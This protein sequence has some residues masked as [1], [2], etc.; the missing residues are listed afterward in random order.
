MT[1][2]PLPPTAPQLRATAPPFP[3]ST[4][5]RAASRSSSRKNWP[6]PTPLARNRRWSFCSTSRTTPLSRTALLRPSRSRSVRRVTFYQENSFG[7]TWLEG[8]TVGWYTIPSTSTTCNYNGWAALADQ[9]ATNAGHN[10]ASYPRRVY[11]FP[12]TSA[13]TWWGLGT[14]GGGTAHESVAHLGERPLLVAGRRPRDR[15]Q[16]RPVS[17]AVPRVRCRRMHRRR[18]RR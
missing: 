1:V 5:R 10:V 3:P 11:G 14:V 12:Q 8:T 15:P 2:L 4:T 13:C 17:L 16:P 9:A 6:R 18:V 7:Q